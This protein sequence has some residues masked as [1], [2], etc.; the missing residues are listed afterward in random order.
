MTD[1]GERKA[2]DFLMQ[3]VRLAGF[4]P[5]QDIVFCLDV[6]ASE[7]YEEK[8][9]V[10]LLADQK[11]SSDQMIHLYEDL[12]S[13]YPIYSIED[14]LSQE[15]W[16]GWKNMTESLGSKIQLVGDDI[17]VTNVTRIKKGIDLKIVN[18]VLIKPNQIGT[19]TETLNA[20]KLCK[21]SDYATVVSHRSGETSDT[22]IS[23]LVVGTNAGQFKAGACARGERVAKYN[24]LLEIEQLVA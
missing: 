5:G 23:D 8:E 12:L 18:S 16:S 2:L 6:A 19:V 11:M 4:I 22:F 10:Y 14:G 21:D 3:A 17:F 1:S 13:L 20:I 24:R 15:D 9:N 7:F